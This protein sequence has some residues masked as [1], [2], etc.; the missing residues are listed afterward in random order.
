MG[1][2]YMAGPSVWNSLPD[3]LHGPDDIDKDSTDPNALM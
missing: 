2:L 3:T 1:F